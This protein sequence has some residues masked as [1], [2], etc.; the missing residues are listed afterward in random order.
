M[1]EE[2]KP[3]YIPIR[4]KLPWPIVLISAILIIIFIAFIVGMIVATVTTPG[5][6]TNGYLQGYDIGFHL[7]YD[8]IECACQYEKGLLSYSEYQDCLPQSPSLSNKPQNYID[9]FY[10][11]QTVGLQAPC[12]SQQYQ[13]G[14]EIGYAEGRAWRVCDC[15][16]QAGLLTLDEYLECVPEDTLDPNKSDLRWKNGNEAGFIDGTKSYE[17]P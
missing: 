10:R 13:T 14:Y 11:G 3:D 12:D 6:D 5:D 2:E 16:L 8:T 9:G 1:T 15:Q 17:C 4:Q 7:G